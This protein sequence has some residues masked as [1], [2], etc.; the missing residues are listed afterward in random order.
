MPKVVLSWTQLDELTFANAS[1]VAKKK[2]EAVGK[3]ASQSAFLKLKWLCPFIFC[4]SLLSALSIGCVIEF[5]HR[6]E[7]LCSRL[8]SA[9]V[10]RLC[11][12]AISSAW[13][14]HHFVT[15]MYFMKQVTEWNWPELNVVKKTCRNDWRES[16]ILESYES[17]ISRRWGLLLVMFSAPSTQTNLWCF[18]Q[19]HYLPVINVIRAPIWWT[20]RGQLELW[21]MWSAGW[22]CCLAANP[23]AS[24]CVEKPKHHDIKKKEKAIK[25][26]S[27][28]SQWCHSSIDSWWEKISHQKTRSTFLSFFLFI[29]AWSKSGPLQPSSPRLYLRHH[30]HHIDPRLLLFFKLLVL[31]SSAWSWLDGLRSTRQ[32][33]LRIQFV[34][35]VLE[36]IILEIPR[37]DARGGNGGAQ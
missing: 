27:Q 32:V 4:L 11:A 15:L 26:P 31:G 10:L 30:K 6:H 29:V 25:P 28:Q 14:A 3:S 35:P 33:V 34:L 20:A 2:S 17:W 21:L 19:Y 8:N 18:R 24:G 7:F 5:D 16:Y 1:A 22:D 23:T 9:V 12:Q 36:V 37:G 13:F